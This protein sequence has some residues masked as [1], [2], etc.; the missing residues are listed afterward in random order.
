MEHSY[1]KRGIKDITKGKLDRLLENFSA[2]FGFLSFIILEKQGDSGNF[3]GNYNYDVES[4]LH[5]K[6]VF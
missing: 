2:I 1:K 5:Q 4:S 3:T 6:W